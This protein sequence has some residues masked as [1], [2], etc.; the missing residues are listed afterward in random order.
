MSREINPSD[1]H[2][3]LSS[4]MQVKGYDMV[5]DLDK[6]KSMYMFDSKHNRQFLDMFSFYA[7]YPISHNH[8]EMTT[9]E[10]I[11]EI[12]RVAIHNPSNSDIYTVQ[13]ARFVETFKRL[14]M[15]D[16]FKH[17]FFVAGGT[18]AIE[19]ALKTAFDWK[20]RKNAAK[21]HTE[22]LGHGVIHFRGAFHGR[23]G[24]SVSMTNTAD[25]AKYQFFP[26][27]NWPRVPHPTIKFPLDNTN[28]EL[29]ENLET[30]VLSQIE[31][32]L[33][34]NGDDIACI[35]LEPIQGEG[36]DN[37]IR[38]EFWQALRKLADQYDILMIADEVQSGM[39]LTGKMWAY[40]HLG[41]TPD[42]VCFGK[43]A[44]V[45][46]IMVTDRIDDI[47]SNVFAVPSRIN[48]TWGGNLTDMVRCRKMLEIIERHNLVENAK[49]VGEYIIKKFT[50]L[51]IR[52]PELVQN[53]RG[54]GLMC[55][56]DMPSA[57][58]VEKL[59]DSAYDAGLLIISCGIRSIRLRP[60]LDVRPIYIDEMIMILDKILS[61][62]AV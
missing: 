42:I 23:S 54:R 51:S 45:C 38:P 46:G 39:G 48:S 56:F 20:V 26:K 27:F 1:V 8:P 57:Q 2:D 31:D 30:E 49:L 4:C 17:L 62:M 15:P 6:S 35:I 3:I 10:F 9:P 25:P 53:V 12:G 34:T 19:N 33:K 7:S 44:Q 55:A 52:Y 28:I 41:A 61:T 24:Y 36:G 43:K 37:H 59:K 32:I 13:L 18:L 22:E 16:E 50:D 58:H 11:N 60:M 47:D 29:A 40:Q 5:F 21:G 14:C